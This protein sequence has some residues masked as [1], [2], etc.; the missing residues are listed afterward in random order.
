MDSTA[1][2]AVEE[3]ENLRAK[4][5]CELLDSD[6]FTSTAE[7]ADVFVDRGGGCSATFFNYRRK[8]GNG[9]G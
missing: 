9:A 1:V 5:A 6:T 3:P 2:L 8:L 7:R 4:L